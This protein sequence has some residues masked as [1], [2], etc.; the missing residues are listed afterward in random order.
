MQ[1]LRSVALGIFSVLLSGCAS[2][3]AQHHGPWPRDMFTVYDGLPSTPQQR[4]VATSDCLGDSSTVR[5]Q[6]PTILWYQICMLQL[7]FRAPHGELVGVA[8]D[9]ISGGGCQY[10]PYHPVCWAEKYGW[11][12]NPSPRWLRPNTSR[13]TLEG[14]VSICLSR[15]QG[16]YRNF[17]AYMDRCMAT[18]GYT[19]AHP[20]SPAMVWPARSTW[21]HCAKPE[22]ER[23]WI[24]KKWCPPIAS[25]PPLR[26]PSTSRDGTKVLPLHRDYEWSRHVASNPLLFVSADVRI[27][28]RTWRLPDDGAHAFVSLG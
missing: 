21:P 10:A 26:S 2:M 23:N 14:D 5:S 15:P 18:K 16:D 20:S 3:Y 19:V 6:T 27:S 28:D 1:T 24:E 12:Q 7:G 22:N 25:T 8:A 17:K 11:P 13:W 9:P 4:Q